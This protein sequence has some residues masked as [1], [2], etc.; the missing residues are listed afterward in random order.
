MYMAF[1]MDGNQGFDV[2][3]S[4]H[5]LYAGVVLARQHLSATEERVKTAN[6]SMASCHASRRPNKPCS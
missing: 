6:T 3:D 2:T 4:M 5:L 1:L